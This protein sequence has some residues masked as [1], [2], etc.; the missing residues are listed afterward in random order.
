MLISGREAAERLAGIGVGREPARQA[1][2]AGVAGPGERRRGVLLYD[3]QAVRRLLVEPVDIATLSEDCWGG[4]FVG[5][6]GPRTDVSGDPS[7]SDPRQS[8][9]RQSA[10]RQWRGA[11]LTAPMEE[12]RDGVRMYWRIAPLS[13][14]CMEQ[15][16]RRRGFVPF[17]ATVSGFVV[18]GGDITGLQPGP[19]G[20][21]LTLAEPSEWFEP[22]R[23]ARFVTGAGGPWAWWPARLESLL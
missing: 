5:R 17:V 6:V 2:L 22:L 8:E 15:L 9:H 12:Q 18:V 21:A 3:E 20:V 10:G 19:S 7:P 1:L 4:M 14:L 23:G 11:D 13:R 16:V